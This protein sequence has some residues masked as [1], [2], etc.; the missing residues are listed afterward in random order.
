MEYYNSENNRSA[1]RYQTK[2]HVHVG[3]C[4]KMD[5]I[6]CK[7]ENLSKTGACLKISSAQVIPLQE[8][9]IKIVLNLNSL[10]KIHV[11]YAQIVWIR[12]LDFGAAFVDRD[13]ARD[14]IL[15]QGLKFA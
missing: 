3:V 12:G 10:K 13:S 5:K 11:L 14:I 2:E 6:F 9:V 4:G 8:D 1:K 15:S 7:L